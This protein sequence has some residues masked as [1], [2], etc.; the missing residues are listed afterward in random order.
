VVILIGSTTLTLKGSII[1]FILSALCRVLIKP[2]DGATGVPRF[3]GRKSEFRGGL[4]GTLRRGLSGFAQI[5]VK[6]GKAR[7]CPL[8]AS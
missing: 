5:R 8:E 7:L 6:K 3:A 4:C 1:V 2:L